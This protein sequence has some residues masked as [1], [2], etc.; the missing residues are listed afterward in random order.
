MD[1]K[2]VDRGSEGELIV[3]GRL[4][5]NSAAEAAELFLSL[6]DRLRDLTLDLKDL[7]YVSSAGLRTLAKLHRKVRTNGGE[8]VCKNVDDSVVQVFEMTGFSEL[9]RQ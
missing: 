3:S 9:L 7:N 5:A 8:L 6:A 4:D 1:V 2:L